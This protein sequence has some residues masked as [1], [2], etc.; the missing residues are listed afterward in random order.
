MKVF[1]VNY[2]RYFRKTS[3][4]IQGNFIKQLVHLFFHLLFIYTFNT[5]LFSDYFVPSTELHSA[6]VRAEKNVRTTNDKGLWWWL[7]VKE[8]LPEEE[9]VQQSAEGMNLAGVS[10]CK[11]RTQKRPLLPERRSLW[12][13]PEAGSAGSCMQGLLKGSEQVTCDQIAS[14]RDQS[15]CWWQRTRLK[16]ASQRVT[17]DHILFVAN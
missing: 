8:G 3:R 12:A 2:S 11:E 10:S 15:D 5:Y 17:P 6:R 7:K 16:E 1:Y 13:E 14:W 4:G 9:T